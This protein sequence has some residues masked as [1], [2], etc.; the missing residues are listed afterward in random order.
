MPIRTI[1]LL[2]FAAI[3]AGAQQAAVLIPWFPQQFTD[4]NG[5][6]VTSGKVCTYQAGTSTG[7]ATYTDST[8]SVANSV[9]PNAI[10]LDGSGRPQSGGI[11]A[12]PGTA[13][14]FVLMTAGTDSTCST[15]SVIKTVDNVAAPGSPIIS[16]LTF[17]AKCNGSSDDTAAF[18]A[19]VA[20]S[21]TDIQIPSGATCITG[22]VTV[23]TSKRFWSLGSG[24]IKFKAS[25]SSGAAMFTLTADQVAFDNLTLDGNAGNQS[26]NTNLIYSGTARDRIAISR[27]RFTNGKGY[28]IQ[29]T[30]ATQTRWTINDSSVDNWTSAANQ[31]AVSINYGCS[32]CILARN[33]FGQA[34]GAS[35]GAIQL[36][37]SGANAS[38]NVTIANNV[39]DGVTD[40]P[41]ELQKCT[42]CTVTG[43]VI[44]NT[45]TRGITTSAFVGSI[46]GNSI[47]DQS[48]YA[49][50]AGV[51]G[52]ATITGNRINNVPVGIEMDQDLVITGPS[53]DVTITGNIFNNLITGAPGT[54]GSAITMDE[55]QRCVVSSNE[56]Y[57][58][59]TTCI[60]QADS[61][62][63][64]NTD[65][66]ITENLFVFHATR[67]AAP[68]G[69]QLFD[70]THCVV[71]NNDFR[72]DADYATSNF[73]GPIIATGT[74]TDIDITRNRIV[75][76]AGSPCSNT[77][78][79]VQS[80][81]TVTTMRV[82]KNYVSNFTR[83]YIDNSGTT[84]SGVVLSDNEFNGVTTPLGATA[85]DLINPLF[86]ATA[87]LAGQK[88]YFDSP[89]SWNGLA[90]APLFLFATA[91]KNGLFYAVTRRDST[92]TLAVQMQ[93]GGCPSG[94]AAAECH[95]ITNAP[96]EV[97]DTSGNPYFSVAHIGPCDGS[98][99]PTGILINGTTRWLA[100]T[101]SPAGA[102][103]GNIGDQFWRTD[104]G[105]STT[106]YVK[107][108]G[109]CTTAG[110][111]A[112]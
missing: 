4:S 94:N 24:T 58:C 96:F 92:S 52:P 37:Y 60:K 14:K 39:F 84:L 97:A 59:A 51:M 27:V 99:S 49:I 20:S 33:T 54:A 62:S 109:A 38:A 10:L 108:S 2:L 34:F 80:G 43:N 8:A 91:A 93:V 50:E 53:H 87:P 65:V 55:C 68:V 5:R 32:D 64:G 106:L 19:A 104:G 95:K 46:T 40:N 17:K 56:I 72:V 7:L 45:G 112:K 85:T 83:G 76:T 63:N 77:G 11:W 101:G 6:V 44:R 13:Y 1:V 89:A 42:N 26:N 100:G 86:N 71:R 66:S 82:T 48:L 9:P 15:G 75:C 105:A 88:L 3:S 61:N 28:A 12:P 102:V 16:I 41:L 111:T 47:A 36:F 79:S 98:S 110:W 21:Y 67:S 35:T 69:I 25:Q 23:S 107:E 70:C 73:L 18:T 22:P 57:E 81:T 30:L 78:I 90:D 31:F 29:G 74:V 103:A